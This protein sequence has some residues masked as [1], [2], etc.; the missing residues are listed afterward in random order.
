MNS[1]DP[2]KIWTIG[3]SFTQPWPAYDGFLYDRV[4]AELDRLDALE[5]VVLI[6]DHSWVE[7][8]LK[9]K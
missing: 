9:K 3:F 2:E 1:D 8:Y 6:T 4:H 5:P 7:D